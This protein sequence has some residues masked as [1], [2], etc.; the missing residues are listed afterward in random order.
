MSFNVLRSSPFAVKNPSHGGEHRS[1]QISEILSQNNIQITELQQTVLRKARP[2]RN[3]IIGAVKSIQSQDW[4]AFRERGLGSIGQK[5][6]LYHNELSK[7]EKYRAIIWE[8]PRDRITPHIK[9]KYQL[10]L[11]ALPHNIESFFCN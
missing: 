4:D 9:K 7:F 1:E 10:P 3:R 5:F 8:T 2:V 11:I 6:D